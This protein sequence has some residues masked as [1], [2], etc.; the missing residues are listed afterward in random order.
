M[1]IER[2]GIC[3][4]TLNK[5]DLELVRAWRNSGLINQNLINREFITAE[6]QLNWFNGLQNQQSV[7]FLISF[8]KEKAGLIYLTGIDWLNLTFEANMFIGE[9]KYIGSSLPVYAALTISDLFFSALQFK[10]AY[11]KYFTDNNRS[12]RFDSALGFS[13]IQPHSGGDSL[14]YKYA[15]ADSYAA[16]TEK[17][18]TKLYRTNEQNKKAVI[19]VNLPEQQSSIEKIIVQHLSDSIGSGDFLLNNVAEVIFPAGETLM[20]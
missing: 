20:Q 14:V 18:R 3:L 16:A 11:S 1:T 9:E 5:N 13:Y 8:N 12:A 6:Q 2:F 4:E 19:R 7:Y 15:T 17:L 10:K